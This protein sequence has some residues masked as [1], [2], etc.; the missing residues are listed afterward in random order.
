MGGCWNVPYGGY[1]QGYGYNGYGG[2][3]YGPGGGIIDADPITPGIQ[4]TPGI[5]TPVGPSTISGIAGGPYGPP[6]I[7]YGGSVLPPGGFP[8]AVG[9]GGSGFPP[10]S[11]LPP[12]SLYPGVSAYNQ[13]V[14]PS[15]VQPVMAPV[16]PIIPPPIVTA[17]VLGP[18]IS[19]VGLGVPG[20]ILGNPGI[21]VMRSGIGLDVD[22]ITPGIQLNPGV[23]AATGPS[24]ILGR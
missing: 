5:V 15:V 14:I 22:P 17:P 23:V 9:Y 3:G 19:A 18:N 7:G 12:G 8:S 11:G 21:G 13:S 2:Y 10:G 6:P 1:G 4:S 24:Y 16:A 20:G